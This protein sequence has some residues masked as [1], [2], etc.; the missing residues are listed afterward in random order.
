MGRLWMVGDLNGWIGD[1]VSK[2]ITG[3]MKNP[4]ENEN[5]RRVVNLCAERVL[6]M[7]NAYFKHKYTCIQVH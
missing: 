6:W 4:G 1:R 3:P 7:D 5:W 2:K